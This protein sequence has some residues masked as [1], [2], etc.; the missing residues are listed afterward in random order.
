M[1]RALENVDSRIAHRTRNHASRH[2]RRWRTTDIRRRNADPTRPRHFVAPENA[3]A[4]L[5]YRA[6]GLVPW[7]KAARV[8]N[9][10]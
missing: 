4:R 2:L 9:V 5:G 1:A 3:L 7:P 6:S 10:D 8:E